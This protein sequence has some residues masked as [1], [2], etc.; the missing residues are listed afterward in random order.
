MFIANDKLL[1][2]ILKECELGR[3]WVSKCRKNDGRWF[4]RIVGV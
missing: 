3:F 4:C 1:E 2:M